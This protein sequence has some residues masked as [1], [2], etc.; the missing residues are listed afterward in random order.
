MLPDMKTAGKSGKLTWKTAEK[1]GYLVNHLMVTWKREQPTV[2]SQNSVNSKPSQ[3]AV[4]DI[5]K[6]WTGET[7]QLGLLN[8]QQTFI[9]NVHHHHIVILFPHSHSSSSSPP[10]SSPTVF[11]SAQQ[12]MQRHHRRLK[13][14]VFGNSDSRWSPSTRPPSSAIR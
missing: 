7:L 6:S 10:S 14:Q 9:I 4:S 12:L 2:Q 3:K 13:R 8:Y 11:W 1:R 5:V